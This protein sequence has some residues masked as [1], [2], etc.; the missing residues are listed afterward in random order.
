MVDRHTKLIEEYKH[1]DGAIWRTEL[2]VTRTPNGIHI[3]QP[4]I[5]IDGEGFYMDSLG[6]LCDKD[7]RWLAETILGLLNH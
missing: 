4:D 6:T 2:S 1:T 5:E 3:C 7:A